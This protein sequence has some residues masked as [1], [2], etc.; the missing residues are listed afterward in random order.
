MQWKK[1]TI[2]TTAIKGNSDEYLNYYLRMNFPSFLKRSSNKTQGHI[3]YSCKLSSGSNH[4][5][6]CKIKTEIIQL[7]TTDDG[8]DVQ[9]QVAINDDCQCHL[10]TRKF[11]RIVKRGLHK[12]NTMVL[13]ELD[14]KP[15]QTQL[16]LIQ[17][18]MNSQHVDGPLFPVTSNKKRLTVELQLKNIITYQKRAAR[19]KGLLT[20]ACSLVGDI[21]AFK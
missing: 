18:K 10:Y 8:F 12:F 1:V 20:S 13:M 19:K 9:L 3:T 5:V 16:K 11:K 4:W 2:N 7:S 17:H 21:V 6:L 14:L 15:D